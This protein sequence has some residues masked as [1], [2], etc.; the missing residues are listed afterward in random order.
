[1]H[2]DGQVDAEINST[3]LVK[4]GQSGVVNG[5][6]RANTLIVTGKFFGVA[7]CES[8][9]LISGGEVEGKLNAV[10]LTIDANSSFQGESIRRQPGDSAK[11]VDF[12][13]EAENSQADKSQADKSQADK[14]QADKSQ[15]DKSQADKYEP[16]FLAD[17][18]DQETK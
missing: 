17:G 10:S 16:P 12:A 4:I 3:G 7:E 5:D 13:S 9:E 1:M 18:L 11:I 15:A 14:S 6:L 2:I 8:I